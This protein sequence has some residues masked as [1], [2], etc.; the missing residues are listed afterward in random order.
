MSDG[1][2]KIWHAISRA[3]TAPKSIADKV[4]DLY[5]AGPKGGP[6]YTAAG[7]A[8]GRSASTIRAWNRSGPPTG[9]GA[10]SQLQNTH[11]TWTAGPDGRRA[12]INPR[13]AARLRN[14]G[15]SLVVTGRF[16]VSGGEGNRG[17]RSVS[18]SLNG[19]EMSPIVDAL[20]AGNDTE[21][22]RLLEEAVGNKGF[23]ATPSIDI[24][25]MRTV[26]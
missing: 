8:L 1:T 12:S 11:T 17:V 25:A 16:V 18:V 15:T 7:Q 21:A 10:A 22:H 4:R 26:Q 2:D 14:S 19:K 3:S 24:T 13:R 6:N 9:S 23:G 5:G 20:L